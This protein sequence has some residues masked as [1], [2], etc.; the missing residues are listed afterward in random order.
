M[1]VGELEIKMFAELARLR[2]DMEKA[3]GI[4]A[5]SSRNIEKSISFANRAL[6]ALGISLGT[7][8]FVNLIKGS[9]D[10]ADRL[11][12]LSKTTN[13][14]VETLSGL[15]L[16]AKQSGTDLE[17]VA[18]SINKLS[19]NMGKDA[20][21]FKQLGI[22]SKDPLEAFKQLSDVFNSLEDTQQR[23]AVMSKALGKSWQES[24]PLL[25]EGSMRIGEMVKEGQKLSGI[26]TEMAK[27]ADRFNERMSA[28]SAQLKSVVLPS[29]LAIEKAIRSIFGSQDIDILMGKRAQAADE[30]AHLIDAGMSKNSA[31]IVHLL[32]QI[33]ELDAKIIESNKKLIGEQDK[34]KTATGGKSASTRA[35]NFLVDPEYFRKLLAD[36]ENA[37]ATSQMNILDD[38]REK[39]LL[40]IK[41]A[42][43][44]MLAKVN[45]EKLTT[46][47]KVQ[48]MEAL[49][50]YNSAKTEEEMKRAQGPLMDLMDSWENATVQMEDAT[51]RWAQG[52]ADSLTDAVMSGK[53]D[54][55][56]LGDAIISE[57]IRIGIQMSLT[58]AIGSFSTATAAGTGLLGLLGFADGGYHQGGLRIVGENGPELE[59]TGP[60]RIYNSDQTK[61]MLNNNGGNGSSGGTYIIDARGADRQGMARLESMIRDIDGSIERR[62][63]SAW[64]RDRSTGG[65]T[66]A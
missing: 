22:T 4:V 56:S 44:E 52:I 21:A 66:S 42:E 59:A 11:N 27:S 50:R 32:K 2:T 30:Y 8:F 35:A 61:K 19:E 55:K 60:S 31:R 33:D 20:E 12:D 45:F 6:G 40:R 36:L 7:A 64:L 16:A 26:T 41:I 29:F 58:K 54:F 39:A 13:L 49:S 38:E 18:K 24:A 43:D 51:A 17:G 23:N 10:S 25:A 15:D 1:V 57:L 9:I 65:P 14:T 53:A 63:V 37:T 62:S 5:K 47:E 48:Y 28:L 34:S 46:D 3:N